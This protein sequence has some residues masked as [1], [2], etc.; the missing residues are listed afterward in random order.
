MNIREENW[1][2]ARIDITMEGK[3]KEYGAA[4]MSS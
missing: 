1:C 2:T 3:E 4:D